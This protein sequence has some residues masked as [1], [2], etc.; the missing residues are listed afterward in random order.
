MVHR[1]SRLGPS[2]ILGALGAYHECRASYGVTNI[3]TMGTILPHQDAWTRARDRY[4]EDLTAEERAMFADASLEKVFY[5]AS[6]AEKKHAASSKS[7]D[8]WSKLDPLVIAIEQYG[9][10]IDVYSNA[11]PLALSPLWGSVR[12]VL[13][14]RLTLG[15]S[16]DVRT[17]IA[18]SCSL[19]ARSESISKS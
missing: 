5:D 12:V 9:E 16:K 2:G 11:Y 3:I 14:V 13:H 10:A 19:L 15:N 4:A 17:N 7:R 8:L 1:A 18:Y 6:A